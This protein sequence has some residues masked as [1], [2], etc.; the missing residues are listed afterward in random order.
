MVTVL[1]PQA[2]ARADR[3]SLP[4]QDRARP[5]RRPAVGSAD[6]AGPFP[7]KVRWY[8]ELLTWRGDARVESSLGMEHR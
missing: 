2:V 4:N 5:W 1:T 6:S 7:R 8:A 3:Q